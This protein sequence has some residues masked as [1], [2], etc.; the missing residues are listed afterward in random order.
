MTQ[1]LTVVLLMVLLVRLCEVAPVAIVQVGGV[2]AAAPALFGQYARTLRAG[3]GASE[4]NDME[5]E[6][7][8]GEEK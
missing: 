4:R 3:A 1:V 7:R 2:C 5:R 6:T 8:E